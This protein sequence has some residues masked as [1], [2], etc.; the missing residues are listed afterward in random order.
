MFGNRTSTT[1]IV[2]RSSAVLAGGLLTLGMGGT[3]FASGPTGQA[4]EQEGTEYAPSQ[5][6]IDLSHNN[7][8][9]Q[10]CH[11][12]VPTNVLGVQVPLQDTTGALGLGVGGEGSAPQLEDDSCTQPAAQQN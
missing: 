1:R 2:A 8:P 4:Q 9:I 3:A 6:V 12:Q 10:A 5:S 7:M 11:N